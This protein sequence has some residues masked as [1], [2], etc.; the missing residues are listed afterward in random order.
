M[1]LG[2]FWQATTFSL[3]LFSRCKIQGI[4]SSMDGS[5]LAKATGM[6]KISMPG[7]VPKG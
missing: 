7:L 4:N 5:R 3:T 6:W 1:Y 2:G